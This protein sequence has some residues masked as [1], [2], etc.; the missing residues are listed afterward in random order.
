DRAQA[1]WHDD[2]A[3]F[4]DVRS[5]IDYEFGHI[6]G[7]VSL[8]EQDFDRRFAELRPRLERASAVVVYC[9]SVDCA[10]GFRTAFRLHQK[11]LTQAVIYENGWN[12]WYV[13]GL[14]VDR[15]IE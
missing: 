12:R 10:V 11:R 7:A 6:R 1:L 9:K 3:L 4:V 13:R 15:T 8:P 14:P 2:A 5:A